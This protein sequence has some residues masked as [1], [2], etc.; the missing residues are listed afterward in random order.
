[1]LTACPNPPAAEESCNFVQNSLKQRVSWARTPI[2][3]YADMD[4]FAGLDQA[5]YQKA[6]VEA[7]NVWNE[8]FDRPVFEFVG[9]T[10]AL[11][12]ARLNAEGRMI[13]DG[14]NGIYRVDRELFNNTRSTDEQARTS[15]SFRGAD[16]YEADI[17]IDAS[18]SFYFD[19]VNR[20]ASSGEVQFKSLM[21][22]EFGHVLGLGHVDDESLNSVMFPKLQFG[23]MRPAVQPIADENGIVQLDANGEQMMGIQLPNVDRASLACEY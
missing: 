17:L 8:Q 15:I 11:P 18:E 21:I 6:I 13:A 22:H 3:F 12:K 7:M 14:Y 19:D 4:S 2:R 20:P 5:R 9:F 1:M 10:S 16:I 23:Q